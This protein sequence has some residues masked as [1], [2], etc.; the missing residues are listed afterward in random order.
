MNVTT[1]AARRLGSLVDTR[2]PRKV[3]LPEGSPI[4]LRVVGY[5]LVDVLTGQSTPIARTMAGAMSH[6]AGLTDR[7]QYRLCAVCNA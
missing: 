7:V 1:H 3:V 4:P 6:H 2:T 5:R